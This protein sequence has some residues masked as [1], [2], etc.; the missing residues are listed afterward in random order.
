MNKMTAKEKAIE[1]VT[2]FLGSYYLAYKCTEEI[3]GVLYDEGI[4]EPKYWYEVQKE[5]DK[6]ENE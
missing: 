1:L 6:L 4:R 5:I 3:I 2:T